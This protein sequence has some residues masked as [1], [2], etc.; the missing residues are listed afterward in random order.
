MPKNAKYGGRTLG[1]PNKVSAELKEVLN[2]FCLSEIQYIRSNIQH[3]SLNN[4]LSFLVK[5]LPLV[6]PKGEGDEVYP[7]ATIPIIIF[8][9]KE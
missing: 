3:L 5:V 8:S 2:E 6:I 4:R 7:A 9:N 1:T